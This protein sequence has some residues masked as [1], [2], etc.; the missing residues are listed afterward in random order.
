MA[1]PTKDALYEQEYNCLT[2]DLVNGVPPSTGMSDGSKVYVWDASTTPK[3]L[4]K[5]FKFVLGEMMEL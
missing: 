4:T 2:T 3:K 5:I 1:A